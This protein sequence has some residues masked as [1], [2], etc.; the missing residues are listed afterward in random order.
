MS[1]LGHV[2]VLA[3]GLSYEREVS[4]RSGRRVSEVLRAAG[5][6]VETRDTDSSLVPSVLADPPDAVFVTLHGGSGEDGAIRSVLE[7]LSV[8]YVGAAPDACRIAFDKPTAKT[9]V[10]SV[11]VRTPEAVVLPKETFHDLGASAVLARIIDRLGLPLFVKPSRGGSALGA[12]IVR[13][14]DE[15]PAAM[16]G[17]FAYGDTALVERYIEGVEVAVSVVD[18]GDGPAALPPVEIVAD[19]GVYDYSARY[20]A[21]HTEFFAPARLRPEVAEACAQMAIT[22][23]TALGLRDLSRTDIIVDA[24]GEPYFLEVNVAPGMTETSLLPMAVEAAGQDL[25]QIC[26]ALLRAAVRR[27]AA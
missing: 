1:D 5:I 10:R 15:L 22:A 6:D 21:G 9:V 8:P 20:T 13:K 14:A 24:S 17:C 12:S 2:L 16:V 19:E 27:A 25:S 26:A 3:G 7:L 18:V 4:L 23:H 11:G